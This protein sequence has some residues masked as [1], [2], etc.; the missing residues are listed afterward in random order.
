MGEEAYEKGY[1][2]E[3]LRE[4][5][6]VELDSEEERGG[7]YVHECLQRLFEMTAGRSLTANIALVL[8]NARLAA[9]IARALAS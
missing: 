1:S 4:L 5:E 9:A 6:M 2:F 8:N 3:R 7:S